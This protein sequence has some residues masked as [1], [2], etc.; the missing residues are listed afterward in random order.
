MIRVELELEMNNI[1]S[2]NQKIMAD[3]QEAKII[4]GKE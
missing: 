3:N 1:L 4:K 2:T